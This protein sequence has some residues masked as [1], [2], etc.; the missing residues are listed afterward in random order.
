MSAFFFF[1]SRSSHERYVPKHEHDT[2]YDADAEN[3][4]RVREYGW[5]LMRWYFRQRE[6]VGAIIYLH[7]LYTATAD[8][9]SMYIG[10]VVDDLSSALLE[11]LAKRSHE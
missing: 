10:N 1:L 9:K 3:T 5:F 7:Y 11:R 8:E 4:R 2:A 6:G